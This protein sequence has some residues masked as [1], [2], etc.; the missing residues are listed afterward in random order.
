MSCSQRKPAQEGIKYEEQK[1]I[2][3]YGAVKKKET[4]CTVRGSFKIN[5]INIFG[6]NR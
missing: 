4:K 5:K 6:R 1:V 3:G 2:Y